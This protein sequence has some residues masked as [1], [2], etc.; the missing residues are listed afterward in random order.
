MPRMRFC[1]IGSPI[2]PRHPAD[3]AGAN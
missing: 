3:C 1:R 2:R